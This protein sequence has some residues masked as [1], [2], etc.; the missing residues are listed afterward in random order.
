M[1]PMSHRRL[2]AALLIALLLAACNFPGVSAPTLPT[3]PAGLFTV[4]PADPTPLPTPTPDP[5][6][7]PDIPP[8]W[9]PYTSASMALTLYHP[10]AWTVTAPTPARLDLR[11]LSGDA[12]MEVGLLNVDTGAA[13]GIDYHPGLSA[14]DLLDAYLGALSEDGSFEPSRPLTTREGRTVRVSTGAYYLMNERLMVAVLALTDHAYVV[15]GHGPEGSADAEASSGA[16]LRLAPDYE[17]VIQS[18]T[19]GP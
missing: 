10:A 8:G 14:G 6:P 11:D 17:F 13:W 4:T 9:E 15:L 16:W 2:P 3:A 12:W 18:L 19:P 1:L 5:S 7:T